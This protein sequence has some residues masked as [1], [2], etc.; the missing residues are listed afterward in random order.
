M[1]ETQNGATSGPLPQVVS[2]ELRY[3]N[4]WLIRLRWLA[5]AGIIG[6]A[7]V[8]GGPLGYPIPVLYL[9]A[10]GLAV[11][12]YNAAL[13]QAHRRLAQRGQE[14]GPAGRTL[15]NVQLA[16]DLIALAVL[17]HLA[18]GAENPFAIYFLF[19]MIIAGILLPPQAAYGQASLGSVCYAAVLFGEQY[20]LWR[21]W[22]VFGIE[23]H[24]LTDLDVAGHVGVMASA[25][26]IAAFLT[27]TI[28]ERLR[29]RERDLAAALSEVQSS[30]QACEL[31]RDG[32]Q[33]T[34]EMRLQYMRRVSHEL[35]APLASIAMNLRV[36]GTT[37]G[38]DQPEKQRDL[39]RRA[40]A[41]AESLL[42]M[43]NDLLTLS[44]IREA[45]LRE[46]MSAVSVPRL[47]EDVVD[48][49]A[50]TAAARQQHVTTNI[51]PALPSIPGQPEGLRTALQ[52]LVGNA[53]KYTPPGGQILVS[54][55]TE[56]EPPRLV[57]KVEDTGRGIAPEEIPRLFDEFFRSESVRQANIHGTG[58]GL[59]IVKMIV[60]G[61]GGTIDVASAL[62]KGTIFTVRLPLSQD[63]A[64]TEG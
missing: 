33:R 61:H 47:I 16:L 40:E 56:A 5:A 26:F 20:G 62:T 39:V 6:G 44:R 46:P 24:R 52:N 41:R 14:L 3:G 17:V 38:Q 60:D 49:L 48:N 25:L 55:A 27:S 64:E 31:A 29:R 51:A 19:H 37:V 35:R 42:D 53:I 54:A 7:V 43:V 50:D 10:L 9:T 15:A 22:H 4:R 32:L 18:G 21:H 59:S 2:Y 57:L 13:S 28:T 36:I 12:A 45:P 63:A 1:T 58:L 30:A 23:P 34:Q 8:A 11:A